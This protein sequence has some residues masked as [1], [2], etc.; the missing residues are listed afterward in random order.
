MSLITLVAVCLSA[1]TVLLIGVIPLYAVYLM[2]ADS[3][4]AGCADCARR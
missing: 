1:L 3:D 4:A 2:D